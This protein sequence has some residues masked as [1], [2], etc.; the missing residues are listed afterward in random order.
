MHEYEKGLKNGTFVVQY[1]SRKETGTFTND[2]KNRTMFYWYD[3][4]QIW[5]QENYKMGKKHGLMIGW[6][7]NEK[8]II[9]QH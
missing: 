6:Y 3:N 8:K 7:K 5:M 9:Q 4:G 1:E 2:L